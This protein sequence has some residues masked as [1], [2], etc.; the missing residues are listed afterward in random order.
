VCD[1][2]RKALRKKYIKDDVCIRDSL[3]ENVSQRGLGSHRPHGTTAGLSD[4]SH[5]NATGRYVTTSVLSLR[6]N[7][8]TLPQN[9]RSKN[10]IRTQNMTFYWPLLRLLLR[11]AVNELSIFSKSSISKVAV[12]NCEIRSILRFVF[13]QHRG[14][15]VR[16]SD[17]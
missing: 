10:K 1:I 2:V 5:T 15:V 12:N 3:K 14:L 11:K 4:V 7:L 13:D 16:V 9:L 8:I 6:P 17:Y